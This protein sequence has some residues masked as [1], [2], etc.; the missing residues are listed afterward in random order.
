MTLDLARDPGD[1]FANV[2][3]FQNIGEFHFLRANSRRMA[4]VFGL[5][6]RANPLA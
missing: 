6:P 2:P 1:S 4:L 3:F 5:R